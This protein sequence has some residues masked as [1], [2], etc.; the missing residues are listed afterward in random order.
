MKFW[1][2]YDYLR[3]LLQ[4]P[5]ETLDLVFALKGQ[6]SKT[7]EDILYYYT[8]WYDFEGWLDEMNEN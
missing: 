8:G 4:I 2:M 3:D 6:N 1:E 5:A 7:A